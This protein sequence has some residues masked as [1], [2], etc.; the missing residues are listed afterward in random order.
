MGVDGSCGSQAHRAAKSYDGG[1]GLIRSVGEGTWEVTFELGCKGQVGG[2]WIKGWGNTPGSGSS[3]SCLTLGNKQFF[4]SPLL[5]PS[6]KDLLLGHLELVPLQ[7]RSETLPASSINILQEGFFLFS[8]SALREA[9]AL[10][11]E[12]RPCCSSLGCHLLPQ[13]TWI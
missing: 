9:M 10:G 4:L 8:F 6:S 12:S 7:E 2:N 13:I 5:W 11:I 3:L 1:P